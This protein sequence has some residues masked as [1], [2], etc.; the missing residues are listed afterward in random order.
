MWW[1][2]DTLLWSEIGSTTS[3]HTG[4]QHWGYCFFNVLNVSLELIQ[5]AIIVI[6]L[7]FCHRQCCSG[8]DL[9]DWLLKQNECMQSRSQAVGMW[10]VLVDE[11]ILVHGKNLTGLICISHQRVLLKSLEIPEQSTL[12]PQVPAGVGCNVTLFFKNGVSPALVCTGLYLL[13]YS[14]QLL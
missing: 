8:K 12:P 7:N 6:I 4:T 10:Q 11:G 5:I 9:V 2:R 14:Q 13:T 1:L 3:K